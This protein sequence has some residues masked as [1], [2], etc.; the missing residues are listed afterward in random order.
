MTLLRSSLHSVL[1][2]AGSVAL[3]LP[4]LAGTACAQKVMKDIAYTTGPDGAVKGDLYEPV[5]AGT[6]P[7]IVYIHGGSWR[8]GN[9]KEFATFA[10]E[11]AGKGYVG[12]SI[13]YDLKEHS[14][15][16]SYEQS[17]AAV[18]FLR[19]HAAEYHI[20]PKLI[21]IAGESAGGELAAL[22]A[23]HPEGPA[24]PS[25]DPAIAP[26]STSASVAGAILFNGVYL[27]D[28]PDDDG[29]IKRYLGDCAQHPAV[30]RE[31]SPQDQVHAGAP[32]FF[33][34]HGTADN[35]VP[36]AE[37]QSFITALREDEVPV[38]TFVAEGGP[39][40]YWKKQKYYAANVTAVEQFLAGICKKP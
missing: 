30:C 2:Y 12:F 20:D 29:V 15:P 22:V 36:Y 26:S 25:T 39:H 27:L 23:L 10:A 38:T 3:V 16:V 19:D 1:L 14:Y 28:L 37:A 18:R 31:A 24:T 6:F 21:F 33:V 11:F 35:T 4:L 34:G 40:S 13:D 8:S 9:K 5:G 7:A 32:P 17:L